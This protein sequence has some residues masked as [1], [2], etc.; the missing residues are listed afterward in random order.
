[1]RR[2]VPTAIG[3]ESSMNIDTPASLVVG[4]LVVAYRAF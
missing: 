4:M 1:M 3:T 2:A